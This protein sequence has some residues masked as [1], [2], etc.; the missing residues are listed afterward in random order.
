MGL[1]KIKDSPHWWMS[2]SVNGKQ[3]R[4]S[5]ETIDK[6]LAENILAKVK[7]I[8]IEGKWFE[9][10]EAKSHGFDEMMEKFMLEHAPKREPSTQLRYRVILTHLKPF[11]T[12][13]TLANIT[14]RFI[15]DYMERRKEEGAAIATIN[16]EHAMLS[17]A[18]NLAYKRWEWCRE[19]P[20]VKVQ[21]EPEHNERV[22]RLT[23]DEAENLI[24]GCQGYLNGQLVDIVTIALLT[25]MRQGE[26]LNLK[27]SD[28]DL[29]KK[30]ITV[31]KTKNKEPKTV[32]M[33]DT[34]YDILLKKSKVVSMSGYVF[35]TSKGT[36]I[37]AR[38]LMR[39]WY[40]VLN[41]TGI[42]NLKFHDL[43]HSFGTIAA[44]NGADLQTIAKLMGHKNL[45]VTRRYLHNSVESLRQYV[46]KVDNSLNQKKAN[47]DA[48]KQGVYQDFIKV[49]K[50]IG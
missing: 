7:T 42:T 6:R 11:F 19:N 47:V 44:E 36:R 22:R 32:P 21:K 17:K 23:V 48:E 28:I 41:K 2:F 40:K 33:S 43:R 16:R 10:D 3:I 20:C 27:W 14:P 12:G 15:S 25:G 9:M 45:S 39:K 37:A 34:V 30:A 35:S 13:M 4:R 26:V 29:F 38:N 49:S 1:Y 31:T 5:T 18:F 8:V 24:K 46:N 50:G